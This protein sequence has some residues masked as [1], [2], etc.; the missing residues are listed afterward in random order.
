MPLLD[1]SPWAS[2]LAAGARLLF[3]GDTAGP[4]VELHQIAARAVVVYVLGLA[5]VRLGKS[6]LVS[7]MTPVD[8]ILGFMLG[9]LLS[10]GITG[11]ASLPGTAIA[12]AVLVAFHWL[13]T[14]LACRSH[15]FGLLLKGSPVELVR[16]GSP[17]RRNMHLSHISDHDLEEELRLAGV[18]DLCQVKLAM[19]ERNGEVS[20]LRK[21]DCVQA[22]SFH[23]E[24][25]VETVR[26][27]VVH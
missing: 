4:P 5:V 26:I 10:R 17:N 3:G 20:V 14:R 2:E 9:S 25:G 16:E 24:H 1:S 11:N 23:V 6:R 15:W 8:V 13:V 27:E 18:S 7:R 12:A 21:A 19:K 22:V